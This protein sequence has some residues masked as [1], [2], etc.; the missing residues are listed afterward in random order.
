MEYLMLMI[1]D[2][3]YDDDNDNDDNEQWSFRKSCS[4]FRWIK[5]CGLFCNIKTIK[6]LTDGQIEILILSDLYIFLY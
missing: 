5:F 2:Y 4:F 6:I 1:L 3:D